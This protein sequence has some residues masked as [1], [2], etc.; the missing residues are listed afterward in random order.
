MKTRPFQ[1]NNDWLP[2]T[3]ETL[4]DALPYM[5]QFAGETF[6]IKYGGHAMG[7]PEL[8]RDFAEDIV[9]MKQVGIN[10]IVVHGGGPQIS[11]MLDR[12]KIQSP[13][14]DGLRV[15]DAATVE[16]VEMV[17]SG[18]INK[19][20]VSEINTAGGT[21]VGISGKDGSL[22]QARK[23]RRTKKDPDSNIEKI[24]DLGFVGEPVR[25]RPDILEEFA[26]SNIIPVIAPIGIGDKGETFNIN[27]DTAAGAIAAA[28][29]ACKL[30]ILT[31]VP[32]ILKN[33]DANEKVIISRLTVDEAKAL[34]KDGTASGGMIPKLETCIHALENDVEAAHILDGRLPHVLLLETFT[35][36]GCGTMITDEPEEE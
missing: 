22:I 13:F 5:R 20:I 28:L 34:M 31:D 15:T 32:G 17:L 2:T 18:S 4:A 19:Q 6:V 11:A 33:K 36:F 24:L 30:M 3:A 14:I 1:P 25:I 12:L 29:G 8:A 26:D 35:S 27:A 21:A 9:L 23:I 7:S 16:I 10:P